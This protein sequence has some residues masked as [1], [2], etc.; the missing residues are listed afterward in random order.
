MF[1]FHI[2]NRC[3]GSQFNFTTE[4]DEDDDSPGEVQLYAEDD[5]VINADS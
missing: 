3:S 4:D 2:I 1:L 5:R